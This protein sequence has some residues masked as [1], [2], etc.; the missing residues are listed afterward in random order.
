MKILFTSDLHLNRM[1]FEEEMQALER[2]L[3]DHNPD[4]LVISGDVSD[5]PGRNTFL[6]FGK[7]DLPVVFCLGNHEF[8]GM[9]VG[10]THE[11]YRSWKSEAAGKCVTNAHCL[12]IDGHFDTQGVR[13]Y[14]NVLWYDGTLYNGGPAKPL[15]DRIDTGWL[16][17]TIV[18]FKPVE[19]NARCVEQIK[20][21]QRTAG[22]RRLVLVTHCVPLRKLNL[23][24]EDT[25][26]SIPNC[27]SGVHDLFQQGVR[28]DVA[29]CGHT[30]R[31]TQC[32]YHYRKYGV[33]KDIMCLN[34]GNDYF[35]HT[36]R[37][38]FDEVE[39]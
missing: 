36:G 35:F 25:P 20:E 26:L 8:A 11:K 32:E 6:F 38:V 27:Y 10:Q 22:R 24:D 1:C 13:F 39:I 33:E 3:A 23:F 29:L 4:A 15:L 31:R 28:P 7:I 9:T 37:L 19:E 16:D 14:G 5:M 18:G 17:S 21:A 34:S 30:H 12:D 2:G